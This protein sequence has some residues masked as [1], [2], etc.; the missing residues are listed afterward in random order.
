MIKDKAGYKVEARQVSITKFN[1]SDNDH[2]NMGQIATISVHKGPDDV[3]L[4]LWSKTEADQSVIISLDKKVEILLKEILRE[5]F[6]KDSK[7]TKNE[8]GGA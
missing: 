3:Q 5:V 6:V 7:T 8:G 2:A 4:V 1:V